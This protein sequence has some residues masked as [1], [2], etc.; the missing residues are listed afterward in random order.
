MKRLIAGIVS[1]GALSFLSGCV[2][3]EYGH[4]GYAEP[5][6]VGPPVVEVEPE[7]YAWDG[8]EY[9]GVVDGGYV[10]LG[11]GHVWRRME[12]FRVERFHGWE[13][14]HPDWS[15]NAIRNERH[16]DA[17]EQRNREHA[18]ENQQRNQGHATEDQ[19]RNQQHQQQNQ[20]RNQQGAAAEKQ[21]NEQ[22]KLQNQERNQQKEQENK[23]RNEQHQQQNEERNQEHQQQ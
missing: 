4:E 11:P 5:V 17:N 18:V 20:L 9:V 15:R 2:V 12:P 7:Y 8:F 10:Y 6:V 3:R 19:L 22:R 13:R 1:I 16:E 21:R 14:H 23:Q